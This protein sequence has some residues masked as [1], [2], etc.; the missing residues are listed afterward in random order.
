MK[1]I[2]KPWGYEQII[3]I[4]KKYLLKKL[5]M[6]KNHRCSLQFHKKKKETIYV[7]SGKLR[8]YINKKKQRLKSK[9][10][11]EGAS[12]TIEPNI[13]HRMKAI[14]NCFYLEASTPQ[15][16]DVVRLSDDYKRVE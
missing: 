12:I 16:H 14:T 4:N 9:I 5:Y 3:E 2:I 13:I 6:K 8:I 7:L 10:Y 1:K 11:K 15:N